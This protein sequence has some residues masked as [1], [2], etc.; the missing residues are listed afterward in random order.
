MRTPDVRRLKFQTGLWG[1]RPREVDAF[2]KRLADGMEAILKENEELKGQM[3]TR[4]RTLSELRG[5]EVTLTGALPMVQNA[6]EAMKAA[7]QKE[8]EMMI[9]QSGVKAEEMTR[10]SVK[11]VA[12]LQG[13]IL[14]LQRRRDLS[15]EEIKAMRQGF[16]RVLYET[17]KWEMK[18]EN[19][20]GRYPSN[21]LPNTLPRI[22]SE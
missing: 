2:M 17:K 16:E 1:Y 20:A 5:K 12:R 8:G 18:N 6:L 11:Q 15:M 7:A 21:D 14:D 10:A 9:C 19:Y 13:E 4:D 3:R 22:L